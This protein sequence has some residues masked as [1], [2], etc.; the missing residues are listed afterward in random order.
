MPLL[1]LF[2]SELHENIINFSE[3]RIVRNIEL[4]NKFIL[5]DFVTKIKQKSNF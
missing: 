2:V 4:L 1:E 3:L 5:Q